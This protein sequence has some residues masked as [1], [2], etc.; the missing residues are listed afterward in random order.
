DFDLEGLERVTLRT[1]DLLARCIPGDTG[2]LIPQAPVAKS[3]RVPGRSEPARHL[4]VLAYKCATF[5]GLQIARNNARLVVGCEV[6]QSDQRAICVTYKEEVLILEQPH[7]A[8]LE[9]C[10]GTSG[11]DV[12]RWLATRLCGAA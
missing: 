3:V 2:A 12:K 9:V 5:Q 6:V 8:R 7:R 1:P 10:D 4:C 11:E